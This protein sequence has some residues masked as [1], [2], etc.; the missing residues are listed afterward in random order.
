MTPSRQVAVAGSGVRVLGPLALVFAL[1]LSCGDDPAA[2]TRPVV[3]L[4]TTVTVTPSSASLSALGETVQL[5]ATVR[6]Q[7]GNVMPGVVVSWSSSA[8]TAATVD[9]AGMVTAAGNG[10]VTVAATAGGARGTAAVTV[11]VANEASPDRVALTALYEAADGRNW[12]RR[13]NW[14]TDAPVG[15]WFGVETDGEGRVTSL[16]LPVNGLAGSI[17]SELGNLS[18]LE[19]LNL[20]GNNLEGEIP[21]ELGNLS[22]LRYLNLRVNAVDG[23]LPPELSGLVN[24]RYLVVARNLL[25]GPIPPELGDLSSLE[26]L[27][28]G[29]NELTGPVPPELGNL[30]ELEVLSVGRND[31]AG[32]IPPELGDLSSL[33][34]LYADGNRLTGRIPPELGSLANLEDLRLE[35]NG[36][37]GAL[38]ASLVRIE[39][40]EDLRFAANAGLCVP[41]GSEFVEWARGLERLDG[42]F[43]NEAD[44]A[45]LNALHEAA[46]GADWTNSGGWM[47]EDAVS[48][49]HGVSADSLGRVTGIDLAANGLAGLIPHELG[50]LGH[51]T[52]LELGDNALSG[53]LPQ[54]LARIPLRE[55]R[56][57]GTELCAPTAM[58][59]QEWLTGI[60]RH[61]GTGVA[62][63]AMPDRD[64]LATLY[65]ATDGPNWTNR[66]NWLTDAPLEEWHGV[67]VD[68]EGR[69]TYLDLS[70]NGLTGLIPP[71]LGDLSRLEDLF[72]TDN[73]LEGLIPPEF[74]DLSSLTS[75][76]LWG[77]TISGPLPP[78]LGRLS[79]LQDLRVANNR[80]TGPVPPELGK[81]SNLRRLYARGNR[82]TGP[83]P[84]ELGNLSELDALDLSGN[85]LTGPIPPELGNLSNLRDLRLGRN[86][87]WAQRPM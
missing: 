24:L 2:P 68:G 60:E 16:D 86:I 78:E 65:E 47:E 75:L 59:F 23:S 27:Y 29:F 54:S 69:V 49:W 80:L 43:C 33:R 3:L 28:V 6:D 77:N 40:L 41:G 53:R 62:C 57:A 79:D 82:L 36:L 21:P 10:S 51:L 66:D 25:T 44:I 56:Y 70:D 17:P 76:N 31:L 20:S 45:A 71:E 72:L 11:S 46:G 38:P 73:D 61:E 85:P 58:A 18:R 37:S 22:R 12:T 84:P 1:A 52:V 63:E 42:P 74:G 39:G 50:D 55:F 32:P 30:S 14:L 48:E 9:A 7:N 67:G 15:E 5:T 4:P 35:G 26:R 81:L 34:F 19:S 64:V 13:D 87:N 8:P 83:L